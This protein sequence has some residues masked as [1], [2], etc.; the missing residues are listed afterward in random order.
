MVFISFSTGTK[1]IK[2]RPRNAG[3]IIENI[4]GCF[5]SEHSVDTSDVWQYLQSKDYSLQVYS[6]SDLS[7]RNDNVPEIRTTELNN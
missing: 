2:N 7:D 1:I 4:S 5:F 6:L 3:V